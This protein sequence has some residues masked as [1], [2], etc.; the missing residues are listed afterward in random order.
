[1]N[2][3]NFLSLTLKAVQTVDHV[4]ESGELANVKNNR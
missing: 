1:M 3:Y 2:N 4:F